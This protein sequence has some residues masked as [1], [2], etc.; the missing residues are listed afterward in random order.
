MNDNRTLLLV[1]SVAIKMRTAE[2]TSDRP[3]TTGT[4]NLA[5]RLATY[6]DFNDI[7]WHMI[8]YV[9]I[10]LI[11]YPLQKLVAPYVLS[12]GIVRWS[13]GQGTDALRTSC[14]SLGIV[15]SL[16]WSMWAALYYINLSMQQRIFIH[17]RQQMVKD[18]ILAAKHQS[19]EHSLG[20]LVTHLENIPQILEQVVYKLFNYIVPE[21]TGIVVMTAF[22]FYVD[23]RLGVATIGYLAIS[24]AYF[25]TFIGRSQVLAKADYDHQARYNQRIH[26]TVDNLAYIQS[27]QSE[28]FELDRLATDSVAFLNTKTRFCRRNSAFIAGTNVLLIMYAFTMLWIIYTRMSYKHVSSYQLAL[29]GT[30]LVVLYAQLPDLDYAKYLFTELYN[31]MYKSGVFF[32]ERTHVPRAFTQRHTTQ[33]AH[34]RVNSDA[35]LLVAH[36]LTYQHADQSRPVFTGLNLRV[37]PR[38][39]HAIRGPSGGGKTTLAKLLAGVYPSP[40]AG[41]LEVLGRTVTNDPLARQTHIAYIP[42]HV[43]LFEGTMLDN[44]RYTCTHLSEKVVDRQLR[45]FDVAH[46]LQRHPRDTAYLQRTVGV[47]GSEL[48]GGQKQ[49]VLLM[50]TYFETTETR[51]GTTPRT[52]KSIVI[53][54]EPTASLD[55]KMVET[56][57]TLLHK[58]AR[59]H[60]LLVI[61]H[62]ARV[63]KRCDTQWTMPTIQQLS[64]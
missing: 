62:D 5:L 58:M 57:M 29:S 9:L 63:A 64:Q 28:P 21:I 30:V 60:A 15:I 39:L 23:W 49:I 55:P 35:P 11:I 6:I 27:S 59:T 24:A 10:V 37:S 3:S 53:L 20:R 40:S 7:R 25:V 34:P 32:E 4:I 22:F 26:N 50:R 54:D 56:V 31:Y 46:I 45:A 19:Q 61:T 43:K 47:Q 13:K 42:Q 51:R 52:P 48:S 36:N 41:T 16:A 18:L 8:A 2:R 38:R 14:L 44:I 1:V 33:S 17:V 12:A